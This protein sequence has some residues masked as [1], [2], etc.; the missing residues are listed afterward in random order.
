MTMHLTATRNHR[1]AG[2]VLSA[3]DALC[4]AAT[5]VFAL[6]AALTAFEDGTHG[7]AGMATSP[8]SGMG[9]MYLVMALVHAAPW[10]RLVARR[11][12]GH[13]EL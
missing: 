9:P 8:L 11:A 10:L 12:A 1:A 3:A 13:G 6:M 5:P 7:M 2:A 4:L